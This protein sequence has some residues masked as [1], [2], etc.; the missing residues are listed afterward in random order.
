M[1]EWTPRCSVS[2]L[3]IW[4][5]PSGSSQGWSLSTFVSY[6]LLHSLIST[7]VSYVLCIMYTY[8]VHVSGEGVVAQ[9]KRVCREADRTCSKWVYM[10]CTG[11]WLLFT[12]AVTNSWVSCDFCFIGLHT[13]RYHTFA[14][15]MLKW[16]WRCGVSALEVW[17]KP[18][19]INQGWSFVVFPTRMSL[20]LCPLLCARIIC[21]S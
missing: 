8:T 3:E 16:T 12:I 14:R 20:R 2:T 10:K 4:C 7:L 21:F 11:M 6:C 5:T 13:G 17:C 9:C 15:G 18:T 1:H 19:C